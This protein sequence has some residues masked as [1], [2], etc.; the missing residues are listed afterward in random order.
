[1]AG[2]A[3]GGRGAAALRFL[4]NPDEVDEERDHEQDHD[5]DHDSRR[6]LERRL[7]NVSPP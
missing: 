6:H 5:R 1:V 2:D 4:A 7:Q 3:G